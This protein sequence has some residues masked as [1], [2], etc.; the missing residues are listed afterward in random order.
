MIRVGFVEELIEAWTACGTGL[1]SSTLLT[2][3]TPTTPSAL[4]TTLLPSAT[5]ARLPGL[6]GVVMALPA[7]PAMRGLAECKSNRQR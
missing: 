4:P 3:P 6:G 7:R 1:I 2:T 5:T